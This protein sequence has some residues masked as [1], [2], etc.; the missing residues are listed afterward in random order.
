MSQR[1]SALILRVGMFH[2]CIITTAAWDKVYPVFGHILF[3]CWFHSE[4]LGTC[5]TI[6]E[7]CSDVLWIAYILYIFRDN[8]RIE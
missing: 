2:P 8:F 4:T 5:C 3:C 1:F 7:Y 6:L